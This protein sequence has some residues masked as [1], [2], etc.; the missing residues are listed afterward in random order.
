[1]NMYEWM[2]LNG[3]ALARAVVKDGGV[4]GAESAGLIEELH[5]QLDL[6]RGVRGRAWKLLREKLRILGKEDLL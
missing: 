4:G 5:R 1:M 2:M 6:P 3:D